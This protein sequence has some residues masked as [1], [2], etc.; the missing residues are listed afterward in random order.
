MKLIV[1]GT[2]NQQ[3]RCEVIEP[4]KKFKCGKCRTGVI[5]PFFAYKCAI[6]G[7]KV[8]KIIE[9]ASTGSDLPPNKGAEQ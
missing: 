5:L 7:A 4:K 1:I 2:D 6:C 3:Y 9:D 8:E